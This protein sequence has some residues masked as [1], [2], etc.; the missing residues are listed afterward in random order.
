MISGLLK[1]STAREPWRYEAIAD[2][3]GGLC[4]RRD[5]DTV[6]CL[7]DA[8]NPAAIVETM[9]A[10]LIGVMAINMAPFQMGYELDA[11]T[12]SLVARTANEAIT[13][14]V[15]AHPDRFVGMG[16]L[17]MQEPE[18]AIAE[19]EWV[20]TEA[21]M[22]GV[23]LGSNVGGVY[24]GDAR[25][26]PVWEAIADL[27]AAVF[28]HPLNLLGSDRLGDY[29]LA[30]L[31][32]NP[33]E[34]ARSIADVIFS[35]LLDDFPSLRICFAHGGGAASILLGRWDHGYEKRPVARGRL[36][37]PPGDFFRMLYFDHIAHSERAL[38]YLL[39][40]VGADHVVIGT[41]FPFDMGPSDPVGSVESA[42]TLT[43][44]EKVQITSITARRFLGLNA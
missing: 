27:D 35:G 8:I 4:L 32:G 2:P 43:A 12:G 5:D 41:D 13:A 19:L 16:T 44:D 23:Q 40:I 26:R 15:E 10:L 11:A 42:A 7:Y 3:G 36:T 20:M 6:P 31:I 9:D 39:D 18:S 34:S 38:R 33:V 14:A 29:F 28:I 1:S 24:L 22:K 21:R 30:N 37:R 25:F 17:P